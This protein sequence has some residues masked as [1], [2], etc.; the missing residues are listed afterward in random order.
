MG[1][2]D[3]VD[4]MAGLPW[5]LKAP[6]YIG[7]H[8]TGSLSGWSS[9]K[10]VILTL[11]GKLTV[12]GGTGAIVEYYGEG[13]DS[14]SCT[15]MGTICNMGAEIGATTSL[16]PFNH[17]MAKYLRSTKRGAIAD[18]AERFSSLLTADSGAEY[19]EVIEIDLSSLEPHLNGPFTPD[20]AHKLSEF[21]KAVKVSKCCNL[22]QTWRSLVD[23]RLA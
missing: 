17:R 4:V 16:F 11:A 1:G 21:G 22:N 23:E 2:A 14:L 8:L 20:R 7:V 12:K 13:V 3:A 9:P 6:K 19:D 15:G 10:D 5:E 18:E